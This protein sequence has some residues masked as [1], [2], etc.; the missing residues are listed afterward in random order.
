[1]WTDTAQQ[2]RRGMKVL[3]I[4]TRLI[5]GGADEAVVFT[6]SGLEQQGFSTIL[7]VG[8]DSD[9]TYVQDVSREIPILV[10]PSLRRD[11]NPLSDVLALYRLYR[12]IKKARYDIVHTNT[13]K[14][15]FLGRLAATLAGTPVIFH[16]IH[17]ITFHDFRHPFVRALYILFEKI[18]SVV[19]DR[20]IA[21]GEDVRTYYLRHGI[22]SPQRYTVIHTGME[23]ERFFR[24]GTRSHHERRRIRNALQLAE[25]DLVVGHVSRLDVGKGQHYLL[26]AAPTILDRFPNVTF[27]FAGDGPY[28]EKFEGQARNL[29][30]EQHVVFTGFRHDIEDIMAIF[31]VAVFTSLWEGL[32]RVM[33]QYAAVG[34][35]VVAFA[36]CGVTELIKEGR[37]GFAVP[38][39][40]V[41]KLTEMILYLLEHQEEARRMGLRGRQSLDES[42]QVEKMVARIIQEYRKLACEKGE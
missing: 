24:A 35:P 7:L 30:I 34:K 41:D 16:T 17:G 39:K 29:G 40:D 21:V 6:V 8:G 10:E 15:G 2:K 22:G 26:Q 23:L 12:H 5:R 42:W 38:I 19:T 32:P 20:F 37:N 33:V 9:R 27:V 18:T 1:M 13:A 31:D 28:R 14:A 36:I 25:T 3:H 4:L 11:V